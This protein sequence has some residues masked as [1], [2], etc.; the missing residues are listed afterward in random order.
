MAQADVIAEEPV[1]L[2]GARGRR[3]TIRGVLRDRPSALIG[4]GVLLAFVVIAIVGPMLTPYGPREKVG[5]PFQPPSASHPLGLDDAG[6]DM[7]TLLMVGARVSLVVGFS[8]AAI[9]MAIGTLIGLLAGYYGGKTDTGLMRMTDYFLVIPDVPLMIVIA[10]IWGQNLL[11]I[12]L[13]IGLLLWTWTARVIRAQVKSTRERVYVRRS[14]ALGAG[15]RHTIVAHVLP[16]VAPLIVA[17]AV[18]MIAIAIF[19]ETA[20][21]YL[22]LGDPTAI[23]W[24]K[25][26]E[27]ASK[28]AAVSAGAWWA[29]VPPGVCVALVILACTMMGQALEDAL[30]PRLR[31]SYLAARGF[32]LK[33][34]QGEGP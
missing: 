8:A 28:S 11:Y 1:V 24:G 17:N 32:R 29:I 19:D 31:T 16:Q 25:L 13:I 21:A 26:I 33:R 18:L 23:S 22:G 14:I 10:A 9:A 15:I 3:T 6:V 27:N 4:L 34:L 5:V 12:I 20:L 2:G 7:V 30:N